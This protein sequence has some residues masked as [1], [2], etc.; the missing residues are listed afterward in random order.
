MTDEKISL[1]QW[2]AYLNEKTEGFNCPICRHNEWE[3]QRDK[4]GNV[5]DVEI[6][7]HAVWED[8]NDPSKTDF[9]GGFEAAKEGREYLPPPAPERI[10]PPSL[11]THVVVI[12]CSHC[13]WVGLFDRAFVEEKLHG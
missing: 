8:L 11:L 12:R 2:A 5:C 7:D 6:L 4:Q 1:A 10:R 3:T 13:G 9:V